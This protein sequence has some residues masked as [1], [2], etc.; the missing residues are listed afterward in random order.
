MKNTFSTVSRKN[1]I[2]IGLALAVGVISSLPFVAADPATSMAVDRSDTFSDF[3]I[4]ENSDQHVLTLELTN[5]YGVAQQIDDIEFFSQTSITDTIGLTLSGSGFS[6]TGSGVM[7]TGSGNTARVNGGISGLTLNPSETVEINVNA[8]FSAQ[9]GAELF[10]LNVS[11]IILASGDDSFLASGSGMVTIANPLRSA[12]LNVAEPGFEAKP[13]SE[14]VQPQVYNED[15]ILPVG[16]TETFTLTNP[17]ALLA[18]ESV[19]GLTQGLTA[20]FGAGTIITKDA[21]ETDIWVGELQAPTIIGLPSASLFPSGFIP[22]R[23]IFVGSDDVNL[24][25]NQEVSITVPMSG[26]NKSV[27]SSI[28]NGLTWVFEDTCAVTNR[29]CTFQT[30]HFTQFTIG[31]TEGSTASIDANANGSGG[32]QNYARN[33]DYDP[34]V[35]ERGAGQF[36][37]PQEN[38]QTIYK[39]SAKKTRH[40]SPCDLAEEDQLGAR[41]HNLKLSQGAP[42]GCR[43]EVKVLNNPVP[44]RTFR[45]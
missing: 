29:F 2:S 8:D 3:D 35:S 19:E 7:L 5:N 34:R 40:Y 27:Y 1:F 11:D 41:L 13:A 9:T 45:R 12:K 38:K 16:S 20:T 43:E 36:S 39:R 17:L 24:N 21:A 28:D 37:T 30:T 31:S 42:R 32:G 23:S 10:E 25:F 33:G 14:F 4:V 44:Y 18:T 22:E 26:G 15:I 6:F